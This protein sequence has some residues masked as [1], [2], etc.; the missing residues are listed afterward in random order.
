[1]DNVTEKYF[2]P[3]TSDR[4]ISVTACGHQICCS[5]RKNERHVRRNYSV[6]FILDGKG[7]FT[8]GNKEYSLG[9]GQGFVLIPDIPVEYE[10][11]LEDP[12]TYFYIDFEGPDSVKMLKSIGVSAKN[13]AFEFELDE[14]LLHTLSMLLSAAKENLSSGYDITGYFLVAMGNPITLYKRNERK[15]ESADQYV[16]QACSYIANH[17]NT[18]ISTKD[19]AAAIN[20]DRTHLYRLFIK[21]LKLTPSEY[22]LNSR[23]SRAISLMSNDSLTLTE[24][25][26]STGFYSLSHFTRVFLKK[27]GETPHTYRKALKSDKQI[28]S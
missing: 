2:I 3:C 19:V 1:M 14:K 16:H 23:I 26:R 5:G 6:H 11:D 9:K 27:I 8:L 15:S 21:T 12:W 18:N 17:L 10:A 22:L 20:I 4:G 28:N 7:K 24:I 13:G 25:A